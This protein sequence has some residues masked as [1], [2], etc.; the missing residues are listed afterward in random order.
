MTY[1]G[2]SAGHLAHSSRQTSSVRKGDIMPAQLILT[3]EGVTEQEYRAVNSA[4][5]VDPSSPA[6]WPE[7]MIMHA[8]GLNGDGHLVV[9]EVWESPAQQEAFLEDRLGPALAEGGISEPPSSVVWIDLVSH[10]HLGA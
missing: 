2:K 3:F 6:N 9:T 4:L 5:G 8:A 7:G 1:S 10:V